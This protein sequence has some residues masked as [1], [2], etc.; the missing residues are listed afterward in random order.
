MLSTNQDVQ[1]PIA[2]GWGPLNARAGEATSSGAGSHGR[3]A[4]E[5]SD[6]A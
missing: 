5:L 1:Y 3:V 6:I 4:P 2:P